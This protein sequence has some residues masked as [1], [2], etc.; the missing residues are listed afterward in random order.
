MRYQTK[1]FLTTCTCIVVMVSCN[2]TEKPL[3]EDEKE[4]IKVEV[5][6]SIEKH[7][8]DIISQDYN[9]VMKFYVKENYILF[10]DG[11][12]WG[13]YTTVDNIWGTWL[14]KWKEITLWNLK[15]H[16]VHVFSRD[17]AIDYVEW[18][19]ERIE[20]NGDTTKAYGSWAW[21]MQRYQEGWKSVSAA[22]DHRYTAGPNANN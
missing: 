7:V 11:N 10:G 9:E 20:E 3:S 6:A 2:Q 16:K 12:Y 14:P 1:L 8:E 22:I 13:D 21:G 17:A 5:I 19:H 18:E 15:N 4:Q